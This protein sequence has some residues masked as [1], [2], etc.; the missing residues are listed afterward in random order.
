MPTVSEVNG[1]RETTHHNGQTTV[2]HVEYQIPTVVVKPNGGVF[3]NWQPYIQDAGK[4][5]ALAAVLLKA[6]EIAEGRLTAV[7]RDE[8]ATP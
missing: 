4:L 1:V 5:R 7:N 3:C 6:A 2:L 8:A